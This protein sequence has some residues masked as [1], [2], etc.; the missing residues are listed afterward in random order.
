M[1]TI[2]W[3]EDESQ[4]TSLVSKT[5]AEHGYRTIVRDNAKE[6][7][8][9]LAQTVPD[10]IIIDIK[11]GDD[12]GIDLFHTIKGSERLKDIPVIFLTAYNS[13]K[14]AMDAKKDGALDYITKPFDVDYLMDRI[15]QIIPLK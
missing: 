14:M 15:E 6:A 4:Q 10:L 13:L 12:N 7:L 8:E 2:L 11:L 3:L 1:K 5:F 9:A